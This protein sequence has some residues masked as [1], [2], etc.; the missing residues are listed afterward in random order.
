MKNNPVHRDREEVEE[1]VEVVRKGKAE[2]GI[3]VG[4]GAPAH[5]TRC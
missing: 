3:Y 1:D 5:V 2:E 4:V